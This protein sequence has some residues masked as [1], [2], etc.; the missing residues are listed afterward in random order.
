MAKK[1]I[2]PI[3]L[4]I[5]DTQEDFDKLIAFRTMAIDTQILNINRP[6]NVVRA[7]D[8]YSGFYDDTPSVTEIKLVLEIQETSL[9]EVKDIVGTLTWDGMKSETYEDKLLE[10]INYEFTQEQD[11]FA[12]YIRYETIKPYGEIFSSLARDCRAGNL[13]HMTRENNG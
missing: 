9:N 7:R 3:E 11:I 8:I 5:E 4:R 6:D 2:V 10:L 12:N 1:K 13:H